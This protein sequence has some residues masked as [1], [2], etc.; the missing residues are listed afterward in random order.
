ME[1]CSA[2]LVLC[3]GNSLVTGEF[4]TQRPVTLS[5]DVSCDLQLNKRFNKQSRRWWF[6]TLPRSLWRPCNDL[7]LL[8]QYYCRDT[9][10][11]WE[12]FCILPEQY[13]CGCNFIS[14]LNKTVFQEYKFWIWSV[15]KTF[16]RKPNDV[17]SCKSRKLCELWHTNIWPIHWKMCLLFRC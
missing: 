14:L 11:I 7:I 16:H 1:T 13:N 4:P 9:V 3:A 10:H 15:S 2:L 8:A 12:L 5:F 6:E 17:N